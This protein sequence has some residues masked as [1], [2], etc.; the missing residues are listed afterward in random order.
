[1][2]T[3]R[4]QCSSFIR[5]KFYKTRLVPLGLDLTRVLKAYA[6]WRAMQHPSG[7]E[8]PFFVSRTGAP[9]T[10]RAAEYTFSRL[11]LRAG[12]LR[13]D[14]LVISRAFTISALKIDEWG[15][16]IDVNIKGVLYGIATALPQ[17]KQQKAAQI[18]N[19]S[20]SGR[21][22]GWGGVVYC[23]NKHAI[24]AVRR[25]APG[26]EALQHPDDDHLAGRGGHGTAE[27]HHRAG[28]RRGHSQV[29]RSFRDPSRFVRAGVALAMSQPDEVDGNEFPFRLTRQEL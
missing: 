28:R 14:G 26:S 8:G 27:E 6:T 20:I 15:R 21:P 17:M 10:R 16:M 18:F 13:H 1:M 2:S 11:R 19:V 29:L 3:S 5:A 4:A 9:L 25:T 7:P 22:Q 24:R 12:V 23:A